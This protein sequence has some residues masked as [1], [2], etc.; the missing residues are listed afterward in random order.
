M[1]KEKELK[2]VGRKKRTRTNGNKRPKND[3]PIRSGFLKWVSTLS[4]SYILEW[5]KSPCHIYH[6]I[7]LLK[8][9]NFKPQKNVEGIF[10]PKD[11]RRA[12]LNHLRYV[13]GIFNPF[14]V[15]IQC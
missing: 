6:V 10:K 13:K 4:R 15:L 8:K 2:E 14:P 3:W 1:D 9:D 12:Y 7:G 11:E 5:V